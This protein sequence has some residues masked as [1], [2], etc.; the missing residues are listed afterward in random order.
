MLRFSFIIFFLSY[1]LGFFCWA[2]TP[3]PN[4]SVSYQIHFPVEKFKLDNGMVVLIYEDHSAPLVSIQ[5]WYRV[6]SRNEVPG[7]TGLAH[8]FEHMMFKGTQKHPLFDVPLKKLGISNNAFTSNDYTGYH[9]TVPRGSEEI[10]FDLESDRM[11]N[12]IFEQ[13]EID[14]EREVVKE[15]RRLRVENNV[16]RS[17]RILTY[18]TVFKVHPYKWPVIGSMKDLNAASIED[19]KNFYKSYYSPNNSVLVVGGDISIPRIKKLVKKY[20]EKIPFQS[21]P[22]RKIMMEPQQK[23]HRRVTLKRNVQAKAFIYAYKGVRLG[24]KDSYALSLLGSILGSGQSSRLHRALVREGQLATSASSYSRAS[25][26]PGTFFITVSM[27]PGKSVQRAESIVLREVDLIQSSLV[28]DKELEKAK[29]SMMKAYV[30]SLKSI[31][32]KANLLAWAEISF[33]DY[34]QL[35]RE[36]EYYQAV[37][38][39]D[40]LR[41]AKKYLTLS[42]SSFVQVVKEI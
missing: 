19:M 14:K 23:G 33:G 39:E 9:E 13:E 36:L 16:F 34:T 42:Q 10:V 3:L 18:S 38:K 5:Q 37:T 17:L 22:K 40:I 8:F 12:L 32:N 41:V 24:N 2:Q 26:D 29:N 28:S 6:G 35:F 11:T 4:K 30:D 15:E 7:R 25:K 21:M 20:Y 27:L 1:L 31:S